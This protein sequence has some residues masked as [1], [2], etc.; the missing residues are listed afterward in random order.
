MD[1]SS[2]GDRVLSERE[3]AVSRWLVR[4]ADGTELRFPSLEALKAYVLSG[5]VTSGDVVAPEDA[6]W[7]RVEDLAE[8]ASLMGMIA[9]PSREAEALR[10]PAT[11]PN[12]HF[13]KPLE[14]LSEEEEPLDESDALPTPKERALLASSPTTKPPPLPADELDTFGAELEEPKTIYSGPPSFDEDPLAPPGEPWRRDEDLSD[15]LSREVRSPASVRRHE[16]FQELSLEEEAELL[17]R[18]VKQ[19]ESAPQTH[20]IMSLKL[21]RAQ[22]QRIIIG[23][24]VL[25]ML[26]AAAIF[27]AFRNIQKASTPPDQRMSA[28]NEDQKEPPLGAKNEPAEPALPAASAAESKET[29]ALAAPEVEAPKAKPAPVAGD[30]AQPKEATPK[31]K[32]ASIPKPPGPQSDVQKEERDAPVAEVAKDKAGKP[33]QKPRKEAAKGEKTANEALPQNVDG[34]LARAKKVRK[35]NPA[36]ALALY[37]KVLA[38]NPNHVDAMQLA[39]RA[40][41]QLR[42]SSEAIKLLKECRKRR[43]NFSPCLFYLGRAFETAGQKA[44]AAKAYKRL[45]DEFPESS[46]SV[47]A[48]KK[49]GK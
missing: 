41:L 38:K 2:A 17:S 7:A 47:K 4:K 34:L 24:I 9:P 37:K 49:L 32:A 46:L 8:L 48:R 28:Q 43:P 5:V 31:D 25:G 11:R 27:F 14:E 16:D 23:S 39:A 40:Y 33:A 18:P 10:R 22:R 44:N 15:P 26:V 30:E 1:R 35:K 21:K 3:P 36:E 42:R 6:S 29:Q 19:V 13:G 45:V 20:E 12:L